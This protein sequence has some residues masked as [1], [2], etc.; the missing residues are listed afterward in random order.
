MCACM[1][2]CMRECSHARTQAYIDT[3]MRPWHASPT[4]MYGAVR[5]YTHC[6]RAPMRALFKHMQQ[7]SQTIIRKSIHRCMHFTHKLHCAH[8]CFNI[9]INTCRRTCISACAVFIHMRAC[10]HARMCACTIMHVY[11]D[12]CMDVCMHAHACMTCIRT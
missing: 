6:I 2:A 7:C 10:L 11:I 5:F 8:A 12:A 3:C 9:G 4:R 1:C